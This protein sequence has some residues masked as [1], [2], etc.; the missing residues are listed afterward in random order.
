MKN[1]FVIP[2]SM[3]IEKSIT[4]TVTTN[5]IPILK[6]TVYAINPTAKK[7]VNIDM[8]LGTYRRKSAPL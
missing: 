8:I 4:I 2:I 5:S 1:N 6:I 7:A 3:T